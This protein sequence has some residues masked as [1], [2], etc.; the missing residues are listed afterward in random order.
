MKQEMKLA[1]YETARSLFRSM[2][3]KIC[4]WGLEAIALSPEE[5]KF[6]EQLETYQQSRR[7]D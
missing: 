1:V 6:W 2:Y 3:E 7:G 5:K 4:Q